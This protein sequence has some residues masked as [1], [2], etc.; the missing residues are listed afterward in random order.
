MKKIFALILIASLALFSLPAAAWAGPR[1][2]LGKANVDDYVDMTDVMLSLNHVIGKTTL[3]PKFAS[4]IDVDGDS[5]ATAMDSLL[6]F[7][8]VLG[9]IDFFPAELEDP[10]DVYEISGYVT[11]DDAVP[12][13]EATVSCPQ[14]GNSVKTDIEGKY[15]IYVPADTFDLTATQ[16][17]YETVTQSN[18]TAVGLGTNAS[19]LN[20]VLDTLSHKISGHITFANPDDKQGAELYVKT[21]QKYVATIDANGDYTLSFAANKFVNN[22]PLYLTYNGITSI[23]RVVSLGESEGTIGAVIDIAVMRNAH[24]SGTA[25]NSAGEPLAN[26]VVKFEPVIDLTSAGKSEATKT[27]LAVTKTN[28]LGEYKNEGFLPWFPEYKITIETAANPG[29]A[30]GTY[31]NEH[32][33][34][35]YRR[36][37][38]VDIITAEEEIAITGVASG[39]FYSPATSFNAG[40]YIPSELTPQSIKWFVKNSGGTYDEQIGETGTVLAYTPPTGS[41]SQIKAE[42]TLDGGKTVTRESKP[43]KYNHVALTV[44]DAARSANFTLNA[45][46]SITVT[47]TVK[48][49]DDNFY[50]IGYKRPEIISDITFINGFTM[51]AVFEFQSGSKQGSVF[52]YAGFLATARRATTRG[53]KEYPSG[54]IA[55]NTNGS[56]SSLV[57]TNGNQTT[58]N[59]FDFGSVTRVRVEAEHVSTIAND[60]L[61]TAATTNI[62]NCVSIVVRYYNADTGEL[63]S[64]VN[65]HTANSNTLIDNGFLYPGL[66]FDN[67]K[68]KVSEI[69]FT[70]T[71]DTTIRR[72]QLK[73][74]ID[75]P[76]ANGSAAYA[77]AVTL[78]SKTDGADQNGVAISRANYSPFGY[79]NSVNTAITDLKSHL[80]L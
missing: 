55:Y 3:S 36:V 48:E 20:I 37:I 43:F 63:L 71:E 41:T 33:Q 26:A 77:G 56:M 67:I 22:T 47:D 16:N 31:L 53:D 23:Q 74:L 76:S 24:I 12:I 13:P 18:L 5:K 21:N 40:L 64:T 52:P 11:D 2:D 51:S 38:T 10:I 35:R 46:G 66:T 44:I 27:I 59:S 34:T 60:T 58:Q 50:N 62:Q 14:S 80:G 19:V 45:D 61:H 28:E 32:G 69:M 39:N 29:N 65:G 70:A 42:I 78:Y 72:D 75:T 6:I 30:N 9:F 73:K 8:Y 7:K 68:C 17:G 49:T 79:R 25:L 4:N 1:N 15:T 54:G 57:A